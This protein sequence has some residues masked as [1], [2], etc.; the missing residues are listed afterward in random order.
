MTFTR[1]PLYRKV[2]QQIADL[3]REGRWKH[4]QAIPSESLL[5]RRFGASVGTIRKAVDELVAEHVLVRQQGRG[6]FVAS[7]TKDYMLSVFFQLVDEAGR[8]EFP[9][10]RLLSFGRGRADA[11]TAARLALR[12]GDPVYRIEMVHS[13]AGRTTIVDS[14]RIPVRV[15][16]ELTERVLAERDS[17]IYGLLQARFGVSVLRVDELLSSVLADAR[18]AAL[19]GE[20]QPCPV[21]R[22]ERT[23]YSYRDLP[24]DARVRYVSTAR[25]RYLC[26]LGKR[27]P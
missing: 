10:P 17:T 5:A 22:I 13:F 25:H 20:S 16:P 19:L 11:R 24:V 1:T 6:T 12:P 8:K 9:L 2:K 3:L 18:V 21:L 14:I 26:Q 27:V 15:V 23:A 7:H 4:G